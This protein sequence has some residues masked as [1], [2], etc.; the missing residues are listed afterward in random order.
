MIFLIAARVSS[1]ETSQ[2]GSHT[3]YMKKLLKLIKQRM[4]EQSIDI[5]LKFTLSALWNLTDESPKT[6]SVFLDEGGMSLFLQ[7]LQAFP[8]DNTIETKVLGLLNNIAE[9]PYLRNRLMENDF[10]S[11][12]W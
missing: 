10:I 6:C 8:N 5:T 3:R 4:A 1:Q 9:V 11:L 2:L 12:L 7:V